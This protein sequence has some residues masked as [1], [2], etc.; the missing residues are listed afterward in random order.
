MPFLSFPII[1]EDTAPLNY[2]FS[3]V[4]LLSFNEWCLT[5]CVTLQINRTSELARIFGIDFFSVL[6]RGSQ[7][8]VESM[9]LRLARTQNYVAISPGSQQ[10][11]VSHVLILY[12][13]NLLTILI[14]KFNVSCLSQQFSYFL[15]GYYLLFNVFIYFLDGNYL[16]LYC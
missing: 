12:E 8:R 14:F 11:F 6:S 13:M 1:R 3:F 16:L 7:Y 15:S 9:F 4:L 2:F 5:W 10:V